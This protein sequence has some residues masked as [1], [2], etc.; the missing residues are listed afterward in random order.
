[1]CRPV[2]KFIASLR[3][4]PVPGPH[5]FGQPAHAPRAAPR[6]WGWGHSNFLQS[7]AWKQPEMR[8]RWTQPTSWTAAIRQ[9]V[10]LYAAKKRLTAMRLD[11]QQTLP[12]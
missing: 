8:M 7:V 3:R 5:A 10:G 2:M 6:G 11:W 12:Q 4:F 9:D 1:M